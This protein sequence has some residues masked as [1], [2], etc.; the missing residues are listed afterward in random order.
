MEVLIF[1]C[2]S[3]AAVDWRLYDNWSIQYDRDQPKIS[4]EVI[5]FWCGSKAAVV[6]K[7]FCDDRNNVI[8]YRWIMSE[9]DNDPCLHNMDNG[10]I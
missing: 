7:F 10:C 6:W 1:W 5:I 8:N 3:K 9:T 4:M 2:G